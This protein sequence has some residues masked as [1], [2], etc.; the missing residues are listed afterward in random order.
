M[1]STDKALQT[2]ID[3][4]PTKTGKS[5]EDWCKLLESKSFTKQSE[6]VKVMK[7]EH[8]VTHGYATTIYQLF[9]KSMQEDQNMDPVRRQYE[10]KEKLIPIYDALTAEISKFGGDISIVPKKTSVS[11]VRKR[12]FALIKP[13]SKTR[14]DLGLKLTGFDVQGRLGDS[15]PFGTMCTH[16]VKLSHPSDVDDELIAWLRTAY[17]QSI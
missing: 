7:A 4:M 8:G 9:K 10:G 6:A 13:A 3:N 16:R 2:M 15:G 12:Q 11:L 5:L 17:E 1:L 14:I